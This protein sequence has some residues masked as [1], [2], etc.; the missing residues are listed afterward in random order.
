MDD[1]ELSDNLYII[2]KQNSDMPNSG[3]VCCLSKNIVSNI[4]EC[5]LSCVAYI[6]LIYIVLLIYS[7]CNAVEID[8]SF[9]VIGFVS[10]FS[11]ITTP[12]GGFGCSRTSYCALFTYILFASYHLYGLTMY[13]WFSL[14]APIFISQ[15]DSGSS[16]YK[17]YE[18]LHYLAS[19]SYTA[20]V[21]LSIVLA[22]FK[23][24]SLVSLLDPAR[25]I[26]VDNTD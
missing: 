3:S 9:H 17:E 5:V 1:E 12:I 8:F 14:S 20:L 6:S 4:F 22:L 13:F 23:I 19:G 21:G 24:V 2:D 25:V 26:V 15:G 10:L 18:Y 11:L 7:V 16:R